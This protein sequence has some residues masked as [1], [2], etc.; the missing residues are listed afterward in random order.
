MLRLEIEWER[1]PNET[2]ANR[3]AC[4]EVDLNDFRTARE[5]E[6]YFQF[7]WGE[8]LGSNPPL[9]SHVIWLAWSQALIAEIP[10][11]PLH[12]EARPGEYCWVDALVTCRPLPDESDA[13]DAGVDHDDGGDPVPDPFGNAPRPGTPSPGPPA[14]TGGPPPN[15]PPRTPPDTSPT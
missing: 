2:G 5:F 15:G 3:R 1:P 12:F 8:F 10:G 13:D 9:T 4:V 14:N 11:V 6:R 7:A